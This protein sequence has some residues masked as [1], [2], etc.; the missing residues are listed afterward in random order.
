VKK[1]VKATQYQRLETRIYTS[2]PM[3]R[4]SVAA[5]V[6][7]LALTFPTLPHSKHKNRISTLLISRLQGY[8]YHGTALLEKHH[9]SG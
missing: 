8:I 4:S 9:F 2:G 5:L 3:S 7:S 6:S 1:V